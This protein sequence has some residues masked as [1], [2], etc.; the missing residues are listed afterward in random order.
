MYYKET[1]IRT[2]HGQKEKDRN[3]FALRAFA[4]LQPY[5]AVLLRPLGLKDLPTF[6]KEV[7]SWSDHPAGRS[8][9]S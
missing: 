1:T 9:A 5:L 4:F 6:R 8:A 3:T 2:W 7:L